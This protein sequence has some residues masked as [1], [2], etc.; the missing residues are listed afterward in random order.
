M[1]VAL[2]LELA[3][4]VLVLVLVLL[5]EQPQPEQLHDPVDDPVALA[6][7]IGNAT[8]AAAANTAPKSSTA[9]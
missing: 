9:M 2:E 1:P 4:L 8:I 6:V 7:C 3:V 5:L